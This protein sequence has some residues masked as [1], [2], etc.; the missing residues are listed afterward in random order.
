MRGGDGLDEGRGVGGGRTESNCSGT[1][2][3]R[4][5]RIEAGLPKYLSQLRDDRL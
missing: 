4:D 2:K 3:L 1:R 5:V